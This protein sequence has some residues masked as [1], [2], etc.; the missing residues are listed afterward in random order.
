MVWPHPADGVEYRSRTAR[1][2]LEFH[3]IAKA[4]TVCGEGKR[5][6][7][8]HW[9]CSK[10]RLGA[11]NPGHR[12]RKRD[13]EMESP[14]PI[15]SLPN[16]GCFCSRALHELKPSLCLVTRTYKDVYVCIQGVPR[17]WDKL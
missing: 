5:G 3:A 16:A 14:T 1:R 7:V 12:A 15:S 17:N 2:G 11:L 4:D 13:R 10:R 6:L 9:T 8:V